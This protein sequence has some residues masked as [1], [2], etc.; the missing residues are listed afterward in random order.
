METTGLTTAVL[1]DGERVTIAWDPASNRE[2]LAS[3]DALTPETLLA[4]ATYGRG[5]HVVGTLAP[6]VRQTVA[7]PRGAASEAYRSFVLQDWYVVVPFQRF[8]PADGDPLA[9][10]VAGPLTGHL[11]ADDF[12]P[13]ADGRRVD[14]GLHE[15]PAASDAG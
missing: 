2:A 9:G 5:L 7:E 10:M 13:L 14:P 4:V 12:M 11:V 15:R 1:V 6:E 3:L 8:V